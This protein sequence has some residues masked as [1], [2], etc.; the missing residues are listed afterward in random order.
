MITKNKKR[1]SYLLVLSIFFF[2]GTITEYSH[3]TLKQD[4]I[5]KNINDARESGI[6]ISTYL[7]KEINLNLFL[8]QGLAGYVISVDG[9]AKSS[10]VK[11]ILSYIYTKGSNIRNIGYAP[12]NK[13]T[14]VFPMEGNEKIIGKVYSEIPDQWPDIKK[15][16]DNKSP[17]IVGPINLIQGG[18]AL[19]YRIPIFYKNGNYHGIVSIVLDLE[20][21]MDSSILN[22]FIENNHHLVIKS[23]D[24][25]LFGAR[26]EK[27]N[28]LAEPIEISLATS[29]L[30]IC[31]FPG[32][33]SS[34]SNLQL[35]M[36][37][38]VGW[39]FNILSCFLI[40]SLIR[41]N[42]IRKKIEQE[43]IKAKNEAENA[44]KSKSQFLTNMSHEIRT[45]LNAVMGFT[46]IM[47]EME[48]S[49][50][51]REYLKKIR[52]SS[53]YLL[54]ILSDILDFSRIEANRL[55]LDLNNV[56][57]FDLLKETEVILNINAKSKNINL[58]FELDPEIKNYLFM[59]DSVRLRQILLNIIG[60]A[61]KFTEKGKVEFKC[62][63]DSIHENIFNIKFSIQDTGVGIEEDQKK[64]LFQ[65]FSRG[66]A[67]KNK[68]YSGT[69]LGL[70]IS[71]NLIEI[72]GG[73]ISFT[74]EQGIGTHFYF[75]LPLKVCKQP[76]TNLSETN[77]IKIRLDRFK[78]HTILLVE[79]NQLNQMVTKKLLNNLNQDV[80]IAE[81]G[82]VAIDIL[83]SNSN[84]NLV[85]MDI[86]MPVM[87]GVEAT[88]HI[89]SMEEF[90]DLPI[91]ALSAHVSQE[92]KEEYLEAGMND[93][94]SKP[95]D[96][97]DLER[98][99]RLYLES[100]KVT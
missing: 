1:I 24:K 57:L 79:D 6:K 10:I 45:P 80:I 19:I 31:V 46:Q 4:F 88:K 40:F 97:N 70:A 77:E 59:I 93:H 68:K 52:A 75:T 61:I 20:K 16:I 81:N 89:R 17:L 56:N 78:K 94:L 28:F 66:S 18:M 60:N 96:K 9:N 41:E 37:R 72:M 3:Y 73:E 51:D 87:D 35:L 71:K 55:N 98:V 44:S 95:V 48:R 62:F 26:F 53:K 74:S 83:K 21:L 13:I 76:P 32:Q 99:I 39:G 11:S 86:S 14:H 12:N 90:K 92:N 64:N 22:S 82:A 85:F 8:T 5:L 58:Y 38:V 100:E 42:L 25:I 54:D 15:S 36:I 65:N 29:N 34:V 27:K 50:E 2:F 84:I 43:L 47:Q 91:L 33:I 7:E 67:D 63:I 30:E 49:E 69:G 23:E